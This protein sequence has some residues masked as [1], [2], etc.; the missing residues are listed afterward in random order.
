ML[1][2]GRRIA[3]HDDGEA[4]G[5]VEVDASNVVVAFELI[6]CVLALVLMADNDDDGLDV[7]GLDTFV[8][9]VFVVTVAAAIVA[10][11]TLLI[12]TCSPVALP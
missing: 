11:V 7:I 10:V 8:A 12:F 4:I 6:D 2:L 9:V 1:E 3:K 5:Y